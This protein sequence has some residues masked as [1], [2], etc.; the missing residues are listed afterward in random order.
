[1]TAPGDGIIPAGG[2]VPG[3]GVISYAANVRVLN[4]IPKSLLSAMPNGTSNTVLLAERYTS[5][6]VNGDNSRRYY[7]Y[8][9]YVQPMPSYEMAQAGFGWPSVAE[10]A[11]TQWSKSY[12]GGIPGSNIFAGTLTFQVAPKITDCTHVVT[13]TAHAGAMQVCLGDASIRSV[14]SGLSVTT[15]RIACSDPGLH[16]R[17][18]GADGNN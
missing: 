15:W 13:Q 12:S 5:C 17:V 3:F 4:P 1:S 6:N 14:T 10:L 2:S 9:A 7:T 11:G 18:R 16:G 8:W